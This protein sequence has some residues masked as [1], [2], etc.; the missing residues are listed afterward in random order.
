MA[1]SGRAYIAL[2]AGSNSTVQSLPMYAF[3]AHRCRQGN[4]G[5]PERK[6]RLCSRFPALVGD[7]GGVASLLQRQKVCAAT[8][9]H[10]SVGVLILQSGP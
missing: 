4:A 9:C 2:A 8:D 3:R 6:P 5:V 10:Q 7:R 1:A